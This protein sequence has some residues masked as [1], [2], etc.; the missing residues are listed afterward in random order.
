MTDASM[1]RTVKT[2]VRILW[3]TL[4]IELIASIAALAFYS[5]SP[6][7]LLLLPYIL[8]SFLI[9][10]SLIL[11]VANRKNWAR[12]A[13]VLF[14]AIEVFFV[15]LNAILESGYMPDLVTLS[16]I[17]TCAKIYALSLLFT[18]TGSMWFNSCCCLTTQ[19]RGPP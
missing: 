17:V 7:G 15:L 6:A 1:P 13:F 12:F 14:S 9:P 2:A 3:T 4:A 16:I 11:C 18:R 8:F 19:S 10:V 5:H